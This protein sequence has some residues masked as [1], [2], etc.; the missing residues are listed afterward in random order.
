M[1]LSLATRV[2]TKHL[3]CVASI[4]VWFRSKE[5]PRKGMK[6]GESK[7]RKQTNHA[8]DKPRERDL[9]NAKSNA[10]EKTRIFGCCSHK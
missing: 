2:S 9:V 7:G 5:R 8:T 6:K 4:F 10:R 1:S 3:A